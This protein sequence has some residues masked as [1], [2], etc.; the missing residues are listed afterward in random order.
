MPIEFGRRLTGSERSAGSNRL[1]GY[2]LAF[3]AG[4]TNAGAFLAVRQ[5]T[6]HV[7]GAVSTFA[8][9]AVLGHLPA[10][11]TAA[12][13]VMAFGAG[14]VTC[15]I[16]VN[17]GRRRHWRSVFATPLLME[18]FLLL[19]FG[20]LA[21]RFAPVTRFAVPVTVLL[22]CFTMGLQNAIITK[23]SQ[24]EIRTTHMTGVVTDLG[25]EIGKLLYVNRRTDV[26][27]VLA[28][29]HRIRLLSSLLGSFTL[30]GVAGAIGFGRLGYAATI[31]L[32]GVLAAMSV[33]PAYDDL[34]GHW[35]G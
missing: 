8:D 11:A 35:R 4:A 18:A 3:I 12:G 9:E 28:D 32:A 22:L 26:T 33:V 30:G 17:Y 6:S 21:A 7:T 16:M 14:A 20:L 5:Y 19:L 34:R 29:R 10:A 25:I 2:V 31:P 1:L 24:A 15:A 27:P 23:V 13:S